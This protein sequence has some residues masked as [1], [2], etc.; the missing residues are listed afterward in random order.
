MPCGAPPL[1]HLSHPRPAAI[2]KYVVAF[3]LVYLALVSSPHL[4]YWCF[5]KRK[6]LK[7]CLTF[8]A[9]S[10]AC[11]GDL[12][13]TMPPGESCYVSSNMSYLIN[14]STF[15]AG[16]LVLGLVCLPY[17]VCFSLCSRA[18]ACLY[19]F[20]AVIFIGGSL[21]GGYIVKA[22]NLN[23]GFAL[24]THE[25]LVLNMPAIALSCVAIADTIGQ[26]HEVG[27]SRTVQMF[28]R[29]EEVE[30]SYDGVAGNPDERFVNSKD[31]DTASL[32]TASGV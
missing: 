10:L 3:G 26:I 14:T 4:V 28:V 1:Q 2:E 20:G 8:W 17:V 21:L 27:W 32:R 13:T 5:P 6:S 19:G 24:P 18:L 29:R 25:V 22:L 30:D 31:E 23:Y 11:L 12:L 7:M 16:S 15:V 9:G